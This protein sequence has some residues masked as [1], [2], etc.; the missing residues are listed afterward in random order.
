MSLPK[1]PRQKM[2]NMMYLV[3]TALLALNVSN[4]VLE[5]F[6][7]VDKSINNSNGVIDKKNDQI[8]SQFKTELGDAQTKDKAALWAPKADKVHQLSV[9][10]T[11]YVDGLKKTLKEKSGL[12]IEDGKEEFKEDDLDAPTKL[13]IEEDEGS[14][15]YKSMSDYKASLLSVLNPQE[16]ADNPI[17]SAD[18][19]KMR[20]NF[21]K[22]LPVNLTYDQE[23]TKGNDIKGDDKNWAFVNFHM[24]P[25][26][27]AI[28]ILSKLENDVKNSEA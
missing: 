22:N 3:L 9:A 6:K 27:A 7:T 26:I 12:H 1:E 11:A 23:K 18:I 17:L 10:V 8:Y 21:D 20:D 5:A 13:F 15:L 19:K 16:F 14:K 28:T 24:T 2:I 4:E 25:T